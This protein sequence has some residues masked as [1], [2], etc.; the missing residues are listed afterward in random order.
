MNTTDTQ[1]HCTQQATHWNLVSTRNP[2]SAAGPALLEDHFLI[3]KMQQ[4]STYACIG[5]ELSVSST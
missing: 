4:V 5:V 2:S 3:E 1:H